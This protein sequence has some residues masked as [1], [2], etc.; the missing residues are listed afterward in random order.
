MEDE[1]LM[2]MDQQNYIKM[3]NQNFMKTDDY[4]N[5]NQ[6]YFLTFD[7]RKTSTNISTKFHFNFQ[8]IIIHQPEQQCFLPG[9][10]FMPDAA[11]NYQN[12]W[13][14]GIYNCCAN[15]KICCCV[16]FVPW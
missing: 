9:Q 4:N 12:K 15:C 5:I 10:G 13:S 16:L 3:D 2:K 8:S 1:S 14:V 7:I 6:P 11:F